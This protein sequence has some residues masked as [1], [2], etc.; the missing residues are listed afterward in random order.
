MVACD[1]RVRVQALE[2]AQKVGGT[3]ATASRETRMAL[4]WIW[5][6]RDG[7][8]GGIG[9]MVGRM[10]AR[11][12]RIQTRDHRR[13]RSSITLD[14]MENGGVWEVELAARER[15]RASDGGGGAAEGAA[16]VRSSAQGDGD[17]RQ[18]VARPW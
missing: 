15:P 6:Y 3:G 18:C 10:G 1:L 7:G 4:W 11:R 17:E 16:A 8:G 9:T 2:E 13:T 12:P 5:M 14:G